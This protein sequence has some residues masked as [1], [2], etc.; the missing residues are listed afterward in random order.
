[1]N[2]RD[3]EKPECRAAR[4]IVLAWLPSVLVACNEVPPPDRIH[5]GSG[6]VKQDT[7]SSAALTDEQSSSTA[8]IIPAPAATT[9]SSQSP[10]GTD[11]E[12]LPGG[13]SCADFVDAG[14]TACADSGLPCPE[15]QSPRSCD[16]DR[17]CYCGP[18]LRHSEPI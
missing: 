6:A 3:S 2:C 11:A 1:M 15:D 8:E 14:L 16:E 13:L 18:K 9:T 4:W 10:S 12:A 7:S 5:S 17:G